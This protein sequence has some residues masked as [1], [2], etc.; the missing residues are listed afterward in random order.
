MLFVFTALQSRLCIKQLIHWL[1]KFVVGFA[2]HI[3]SSASIFWKNLFIVSYA[4][5]FDCRSRENNFN[6]S[7]SNTK[8]MI[9][10]KSSISI[11]S[12]YGE[13]KSNLLNEVWSSPDAN[14]KNQED[15]IV[16]DFSILFILLQLLFMNVGQSHW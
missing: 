8:E 15:N 3:S 16:S 9:E 13:V 6:E 7:R 11:R 5:S 10:Y 1:F 4:V 14:K 2:I 12:I